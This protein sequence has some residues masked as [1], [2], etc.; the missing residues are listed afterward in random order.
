MVAGIVSVVAS[1]LVSAGCFEPREIPLTRRNVAPRLGAATRAQPVERGIDRP[2]VDGICWVVGVPRKII[3]WDSRVANHRVS[4]RTEEAILPG[5][6]FGRDRYNPYTA[7][8][9]VYSDVPALAIKQ[10][11]HSK[12]YARWAYPG[13]YALASLLPI[14]DLWH[15]AIATGDAI[16]YAERHEASELEP[17]EYRI[18]YPTYGVSLGGVVESL[19]AVAAPRPPADVLT[20]ESA[21]GGSMLAAA[22]H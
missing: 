15:Q 4:P 14:V 19:P 20:P 12:D 10:A 8:V 16:A 11:G 6:I 3:L 21:S 1:G 7:A 18:L 5:R 17:E 9:H 13:T 2:V 22:G